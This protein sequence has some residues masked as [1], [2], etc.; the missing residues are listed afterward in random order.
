MTRLIPLIL[1]QVLAAQEPAHTIQ[2]YRQNNGARI[3][4]DFSQLLA[5][6][7]VAA[8]QQ[9]IL[10]NAEFIRDAL[11]LR[12]VRAELLNIP[13]APDAP[14]IVF[15]QLKTPGAIRT[16]GLYVHYDG[17]P[18]DADRWTNPPWK[19]TLYTAAI[20]AGGKP[21]PFPKPGETI[22]PEWRLYARS[23]GDDKTPIIAILTALDALGDAHI[24][25]TSNLLFFFEGEEEAGS[26]PL[27]P[28]PGRAP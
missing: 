23:A 22:D 1:A 25:P 8:D 7:N 15:G 6:P 4:Q 24:S 28:I 27:A 13:D 20:E 3:L 26:P 11:T 18:V 16:L 19:P 12:G 5:I 17:Q 9:N 10:R 14:P 21:R 2:T